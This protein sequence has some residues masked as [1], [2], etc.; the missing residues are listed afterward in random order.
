[1]GFRDAVTFVKPDVGVG[2]SSDATSSSTNA[3]GDQGFGRSR[4]PRSRTV[5]NTSSP[6]RIVTAATIDHID[7]VHNQIA[8]VVVVAEL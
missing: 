5:L 6:S 7:A 4:R 2:L 8:I 3:S 1:M